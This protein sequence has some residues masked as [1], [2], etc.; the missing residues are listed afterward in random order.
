MSVPTACAPEGIAAG[1]AAAM[2]LGGC[3]FNVQVRRLVMN[4]ATV[5]VLRG[6]EIDERHP[7][8][9]DLHRLRILSAAVL[10]A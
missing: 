8:K 7:F 3:R 1:P 10:D 9:Q 6:G 2:V 5:G 4:G